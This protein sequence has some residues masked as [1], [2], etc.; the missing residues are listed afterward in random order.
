MAVETYK[1]KI[2]V[3]TQTASIRDLKGQIVATQVPV[4][5]LREEF[6]NFA[7]TVNS[8]KFNK[9]NSELQGTKGI[10]GGM[11]KFEKS[12]GGAA[13]SVLEL[14]RIVSDAPYGIR[15][16][17]NN[18]SQLASNMLFGAQQIDKATGKTVG[19]TS[20]LKGMGK[21]FIGPLG[22]LFAI[23]AVV[24]AVDYFY[25]GMKKAE[26]GLESLDESSA[27]AASSLKILVKANDLGS[28]SV[29]ETA[30]VVK[31]A[32]LEYKDLNIQVGENGKIT[33]E[34]VLAINRK[35]SSLENLARATATQGLIEEKFAKLVPLENKLK[36]QE[37]E[38]LVKLKVKG[39]NSI[40][41]AQE[42]ADKTKDYALKGYVNGII[43]QTKA[44][45]D[46]IGEIQ[47]SI[48]ELITNIPSVSD[49]FKGNKGKKEKDK[50]WKGKRVLSI[51]G[52][53]KIDFLEAEKKAKRYGKNLIKA[54]E[55]FFGVEMDK[56]PLKV[57]AE[58]DLTFSEELWKINQDKLKS[59][60]NEM[61]RQDKLEDLASYAEKAKE[62]IGGIGEFVNA[63]YDR[64]LVIEQN[65]TNALNN[66]LNNR[67]Q[68]ETLS[69]NQR[70][71]IQ[72][73][74][75][76]NDEKLRIKQEQIERKRFT[77]QKAV[78]I[79]QAT[80]DTF[81]AATGVLADT[82]GGSFARIA[83][84]IATIGAGLAQ[85]AM[86]S[87]QKFQTSAGSSPRQATGA[88][89]GGG[90]DREDVFN[91][92]GQSQSSQLAGAIQNQFRQPLRA[93]VVAR[94]VT[95]QQDI[96]SNIQGNASI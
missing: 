18:V 91:I 53:D 8:T 58:L 68:N 29:E 15:G 75:A 2:D 25:G 56:D 4:K 12:T 46:D 92:V 19:F 48:D 14:G 43:N 67:L 36:K 81:V 22:I 39:I 38:A 94:D 84:M 6:G 50:K 5:Q 87:R 71:A 40:K 62:I 23:Q 37:E 10:A 1:I 90:S 31:K 61:V 7:R 70:Q 42:I 21:A 20:V 28:M 55:N 52:F 72:N 79:A 60:V 77:M 80:M 66:E 96:D 89:G 33:D 78:N 82:R 95:S 41:E 17:A 69:K 30:R 54:V 24:A 86:I 88:G 44:T 27:K 63:E 9:F 34:S 32:N 3:E 13:T 83:G 93:Y 73:Q 26:K 76:Q 49:L 59:D 47:T 65:K 57:T 64:D 74:I 35:I 16:M 11:K 85:V 45:K 51:L